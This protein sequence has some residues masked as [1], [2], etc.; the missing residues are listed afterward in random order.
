MLDIR[1]LLR[2]KRK[3]IITVWMEILIGLFVIALVYLVFSEVIYVYLRPTV[4]TALGNATNTT[5]ALNTISIIDMAWQYWPLILI[6]GLFLFGIVA[7]QRREPNEV[8]Y[9]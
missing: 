4:I 5:Q 9:Y 1:K 3:G 2:A 7:A 6:G 8:S